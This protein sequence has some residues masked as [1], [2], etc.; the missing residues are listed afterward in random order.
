M[1]ITKKAVYKKKKYKLP[2]SP[3]KLP[4]IG[5]LHQ[6]A[7]LTL[8][9]LRALSMKHGPLMLLHIGQIRTFVVSSAEMA[10]EILKKQ[11]DIF[12]SRPSVKADNILG[13]GA[14]NVSF[15][16]Y[17]EYWK[18]AKKL[19]IAHLLGPAKVRSFKPA[20][21][22][23]VRFVLE[24]M[25]QAQKMSKSVDL[26]EVFNLFA[27][28]ILG[29]LVSKNF[30]E[31]HLVLELT[32]QGAA[33]YFEFNFEDYFPP[34]R[35][36]DTFLQ[37]ESKLTNISKRCD[38]LFEKMI[39][40]RKNRSAQ[41]DKKHDGDLIGALLSLQENGELDFELTKEH[42]KAFLLDM[43]AAG[44]HTT[45]R[46][47]EWAMVELMKDH[48]TMKQ[49]QEQV[50]KIPIG[51]RGIITNEDINELTVLK[52]V[53]KETLRLH[54]PGPVA[55]PHQSTQETCIN[56]YTIP[57]G[58]RFLVNIWSINRD[59][60]FWENSDE[61]RP[62]RFTGNTADFW[63]NNFQFIPFG[64]GRR[65]CPGIHFA[66]HNIELLLAN[67]LYHFDWKL[68]NGM[69]TEELDMEYAPGLSV[70]RNKKLHL[71]PN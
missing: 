44:V 23:Q 70:M 2:P 59:P 47:L 20:R 60:K 57:K 35:F 36:L 63:G 42:I 48:K 33:L 1:L 25:R 10:Q 46:T 15:A 30:S 65:M 3:P 26:T 41:D 14:S 69:T 21:E 62:E 38:D 12:A 17:G 53:I 4:F 18:R 43:F 13:Y 54:P 24:K 49:I 29:R 39:S 61:F 37:Y 66:M 11:D 16:P 9:S 64:A 19:Y 40:D 45:S 32:K 34:L 55:V 22:D 50:R 51:G 52:S 31:E 67:I 58:S 5:N 7:S 71:V 56:G 28:G 27:V 6:V 68:P 8:H